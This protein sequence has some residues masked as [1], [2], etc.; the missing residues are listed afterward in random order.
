[1]IKVTDNLWRGPRPTSYQELRDQ[2]F[3]MVIDLESGIYQTFHDDEYEKELSLRFGIQQIVI[4]CSDITPPRLDQVAKFLDAINYA[5]KVY[6]HCLHGNDRT[7]FMCAVFRMRI[8]N[9]SYVQAEQE[10]FDLGF[11][12]IPYLLW[13]GS[14]TAYADLK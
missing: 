7:G 9:W 2:G 8:Q 5:H 13:L 12:K 3:D 14:L 10:M 6:V 4:P 11:H 1:M